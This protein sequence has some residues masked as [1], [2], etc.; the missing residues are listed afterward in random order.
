MATC[1]ALWCLSLLADK[2]QGTTLTAP[3]GALVF[4][5]HPYWH[6]SAMNSDLF[7]PETCQNEPALYLRPQTAALLC[8]SNPALPDSSF[9][10]ATQTSLPAGITAVIAHLQTGKHCQPLASSAK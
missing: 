4:P 3:L 10:S 6:L 5:R 9:L 7:C 8:S 1:K 2:H